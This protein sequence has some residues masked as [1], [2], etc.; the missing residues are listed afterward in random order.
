M[1][2]ESPT[3]TMYISWSSIVR[4]SSSIFARES[5]TDMTQGASHNSFRSL[6]P[7]CKKASHSLLSSVELQ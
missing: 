6:V 3:G 5:V 7:L 1:A 2:W 4:T